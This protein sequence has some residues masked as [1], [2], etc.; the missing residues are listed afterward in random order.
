MPQSRD[1]GLRDGRRP[2]FRL[3]GVTSPSLVRV[4][5]GRMTE[6]A[7]ELT[8]YA[9]GF[10]W[11]QQ[12]F[13]GFIRPYPGVSAAHV[14]SALRT[15][16]K[17]LAFT[18]CDNSR[19]W[20]STGFTSHAN[21]REALANGGPALSTGKGQAHGRFY[22]ISHGWRAPSHVRAAGRG[23]SRTVPLPTRPRPRFRPRNAST[24]S[25]PVFRRQRRVVAA[26]GFPPGKG[27]RQRSHGGPGRKEEKEG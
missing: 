26:L 6:S 11:R 3:D 22:R 14:P 21:G 9:N 24:P 5:P 16:L 8:H 27:S 25:K 15:R 17:S 4:S 7:Q 12:P 18:Y 10:L 1:P 19:L 23:T 2:G 20:L 13:R